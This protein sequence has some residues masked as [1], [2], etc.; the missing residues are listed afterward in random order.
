M[1]SSEGKK[2][3]QP[4][5]VVLGHI[6][7]GKCLHPDE[8]VFLG[9]GR[10]VR[11]GDL[12]EEKNVV[13]DGCYER[14]EKRIPVY[15]CDESLKVRVE[16][17]LH[18]WRVR[19]SGPLYKVV[20]ED[21]SSVRVTPEH[22]F[23]TPS[24]WRRADLIALGDLVAVPGRIPFRGSPGELNRLLNALP[25]DVESGF[26]EKLFYKA[27]SL[28]GLSVGRQ[29]GIVHSLALSAPAGSRGIAAA[30][31]YTLMVKESLAIEGV[32]EIV[33]IAPPG[34]TA[35]FL[36][37]FFDVTAIVEPGA[38]IL[39]RLKDGS[40][41]LREIKWLLLRFGVLAVY[42]ENEGVSELRISTPSSLKSFAEHVG[43]GEHSKREL[44]QEELRR[45]DRECVSKETLKGDVLFLRVT[46]VE[47]EFYD[48]FLYDLSVEG[49]QS[50]IAN[51]VI[52]HNTTLL[53]RIRGTS[54]A[55]REPGEITQHV[56][57]SVVPARVIEEVASPLKKLIP[58][59][60]KIPG[61]L[62]ID[63]PG[64]ELFVNMRKRG[65]SVADFAILVID[66]NEGVKEQTV[67][68]IEILKSRKVPFLVAAN[69]IDRIP[70]W[71]SYPGEP[72]LFTYR[73]QS[74]QTRKL[75]DDK[76]YRLIGELGTF[77]FNS[78]RFDRIRDFTRTVAIVPISAKTG[79]GIPELLAVLAGLTQQ[80]LAKRLVYA[81]GPGKGVVLEVK[82]TPGLGHT[83]DVILYD[84]TLRK[85]D[86]IVVGSLEGPIV[87]RVRALLMPKPLQEI[88]SPEDKF[89]QV[90][91][92]Y[93]ACGVKVAAPSLEK[94]VAGTPLIVVRSEEELEE[95]KKKVVEEVE[96]ARIRTDKTGVVAKADTLGTLE[97]LVEALKR[98]DIPVREADVGPISKRDVLEANVSQEKDKTL[99]V[100]LG[101]NVKV[102]PEAQEEARKLGVRIFTNNVIYRL[103]EDYLEWRERVKR[104]ERMKEL[105]SLVRP[106]KLRIIPGC[107]FRRSDPAI[108]GVEVLG[109]ILKPGAP[110]M[111]EDGRKLGHVMQIQ[112]RGQTLKEARAG[113]QVAISIRGNIM[114][115][116]HV[117]EGDI[118]YTDVPESH[119]RLLLTKFK[120]ELSNDELMVLDE[121][122][123][124]KRKT[125]PFYAMV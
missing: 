77:G 30:T 105:E 109:G 53:D 92:V 102:L 11:I 64:H 16:H 83:I 116:R 18:V 63:T 41:L 95:A 50:F 20:L 124:I 111:R 87:T 6:D 54:V 26:L 88:R 45:L 123:K 24:G 10:F 4:I 57:A 44:L 60:L 25:G 69:K 34:L 17:T 112:E 32:P 110:L 86:T 38:G 114:I 2:L 72:F 74:P 52:V 115:G 106:A 40:E 98:S 66:I 47:V 49:T 73:K 22:P 21:G 107:V 3:R 84:G 43:F 46:R 14:V 37:G 125:N 103:I 36:R 93:A 82:E 33:Y 76:I 5:V 79:E 70:G 108:V 56:G 55:R 91:E 119:A 9:D 8:R 65:G 59:K 75:L 68:C 67:E 101:F 81:E 31:S 42:S 90:D 35:A 62:F 58:I 29:S 104:E 23:L 27:G 12:F 96:R 39:V 121:I 78:D 118:M 71:K 120:G 97:A 94:A 122:I 15:T 51:G 100:V 99:G 113:M 1:S 48:G 85:G 7:H 89:M 19:Y 13:Q 28:L 61:L 117:D 80:Y